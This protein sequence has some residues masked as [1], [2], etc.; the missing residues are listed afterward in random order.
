MIQYEPVDLSVNRAAATKVLDGLQEGGFSAWLEDA[1]TIPTLSILDATGNTILVRV[2]QPIVHGAPIRS[3]SVLNDAGSGTLWIGTA[4]SRCDR[5]GVGGGASS[6]PF[7][8]RFIDLYYAPH[9]PG[10]DGLV[11]PQAYMVRGGLIQT[12]L[13]TVIGNNPTMQRGFGNR[14]IALNPGGATS[15]VYLAPFV[16]PWWRDRSSGRLAARLLGETRV[17]HVEAM[18]AR[19]AAGGAKNESHGIW[20]Q[21]TAGAAPALP[22]TPS[23]FFGLVANP[24]AGGAW[25]LASRSIPA[26]PLVVHDSLPSFTDVANLHRVRFDLLSADPASGRDGVIRLSVDGIQLAEITNLATI[27]AINAV[28]AAAA[29]WALAVTDTGANAQRLNFAQLSLWAS[30]GN[31]TPL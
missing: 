27:P 11:L 12:G 6:S 13:W 24:A 4:S 23:A 18:I 16:V 17:F 29:G 30:A 1:D 7:G 28:F 21:G 10:A 15:G 26:G 9:T 8:E 19:D 2:T 20:F 22:A 31:G 14:I 25:C 5:L 3:I